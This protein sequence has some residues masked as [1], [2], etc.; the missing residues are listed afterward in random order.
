MAYLP[1]ERLIGISGAPRVIE[2]YARRPQLQERIGAQ[3]ADHLERV[4]APRGRRRDPRG[5]APVHGDARHPE[6]RLGR[7]PR[8]ARSARRSARG[9]ARCRRRAA[10]AS[11]CIA[12][13]APSAVT[14]PGTLAVILVTRDRPLLLA[15]A[16]RSVAEQRH[17][18]LE[19]RIADDGELPVQEAVSASG[20]LE[21]TVL[22]VD[23]RSP[24][25]G[26]QPGR[27]RNASRGAGVPRRR[28]SLAARSSGRIGASLRRSGVAGSPTATAW[29]CAKR[30]A[31]TGDGAT[32]IEAVIARDWDPAT[33]GARR[34]RSAER[35]AVRRELFERLGGFDESFRFSE[36]WD[37]LLRAAARS[38]PRRV[39]G[40][41]VEVRLREHGNLS[42]ERGEERRA[43]PRPARGPPRSPA[44]RD[45]D[46]LGGR[47]RARRAARLG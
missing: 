40:V 20:L 42:S 14:E 3:V 43:A 16:L 4:L 1:G 24:G 38:A 28:R 29:W 26:A 15:D 32:S 8:A 44:A 34:L 45:Q 36:D 2:H 10:K 31:P 17:A 39:P 35:L 27:G 23:A 13:E 6:D 5:P 30:S 22:P 7:D 41:T 37:F 21:V 12:T 18:P 11:T 46:L 33:D 47:G 19:V 9:P 25:G